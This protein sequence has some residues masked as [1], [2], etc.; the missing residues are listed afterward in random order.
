M[1][2]EFLKYKEKIN[3][4]RN[5]DDYTKELIK[6]VKKENSK[7][8]DEIDEQF[9]KNDNKIKFIDSILSKY[10]YNSF[11]KNKNEKKF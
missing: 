11:E 4:K 9:E 3:K 7:L 10:P 1:F 5:I 6:K 2:R 8:F